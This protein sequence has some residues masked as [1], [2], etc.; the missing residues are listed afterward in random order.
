MCSFL[1]R[2]L[3]HTKTD[4][5]L[6]R[7]ALIKEFADPESE[8]GLMAALETRQGSHE[9]QAYYSRLRRAYFVTHNEPDMED[10]LNFKTLLQKE[11]SSQCKPPS[12]RSRMSMNN[13]CT[14]VAR[15][16]AESLRKQKVASEKG[17]KTPAVLDFNTQ[18]HGLALECA[19]RQDS[20]KQPPRQWNA[21]PSNKEQ[22]SHAGTQSTHRYD[23]W[24]INAHQ[25][26]TGRSH[27]TNQSLMRVNRR[28]CGT[29]QNHLETQEGKA[30]GN[31]MENPRENNKLTLEQPAQGN[32]ENVKIHK[33]P[34]PTELKL[35]PNE[36][37]RHH[38]VSTHKS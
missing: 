9:P 15:L 13:E 16:G 29:G 30:H 1:D 21:P 12:L 34:K 28:D 6:L 17:A 22:D 2:Q 5:Q 32:N 33:D 8:Q 20:V 19:P 26:V 37:K 31:S 10:E 38:C 24:D 14:A 23:C 11:H 36:Y 25:N 7:E 3:A 27:G 35:N 4:F 18:S